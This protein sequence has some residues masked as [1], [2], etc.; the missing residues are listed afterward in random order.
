MLLRI[1]DIKKNKNNSF[2]ITD[3]SGNMIGWE[4]YEFFYY[5]PVINLSQFDTKNE[6]P[7]ITYGSLCMP[8]DIWGYYMYTKG[9]PKPNDVIVVPFQGA[10]TYTFAQ[11]FIKEIPPVYDM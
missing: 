5:A 11:N 1:I 10:Y 3:G 7:F 4:K 6:I 2:G 8:D 9:T